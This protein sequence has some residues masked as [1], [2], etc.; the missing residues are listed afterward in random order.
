MAKQNNST[1]NNNE[2]KG[3]VKDNATLIKNSADNCQ[4]KSYQPTKDDLTTPPPPSSKFRK[5]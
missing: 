2:A 4:I 3:Q 1:P 5:K